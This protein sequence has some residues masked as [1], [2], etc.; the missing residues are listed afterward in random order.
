MKKNKMM[1]IASILLVAVLISTCAIAG[2]YAKYVTKGEGTDTARVAKWGVTVT[3]TGEAFAK[4]YKTDDTAFTETNSVISTDKVIAPG[5]KGNVAAVALAGT[6]E[7]AVR[8]SYAVK[9]EK[10]NNWK[11]G[12]GA[13]YFPIVFTLNN[14]TVT[15]D[16]LAT[17]VEALT[18]DY[19]AGTDLSTV[20]QALALT[21]EWP[22]STSDANDV[23]DTDLG[24]QAV[25]GNAATLSITVTATVTQID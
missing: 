13:E 23:K 6:P 16:E 11:D 12:T 2:T 21:W 9:I 20:A 8:V 3:A 4:E 18:K 24:N 25:L 14:E 19:A 1:R 10:S 17:K 15:L 5:T 22:F 7:V